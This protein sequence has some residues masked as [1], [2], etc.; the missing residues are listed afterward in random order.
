MENFSNGDDIV[1]CKM[2]KIIPIIAI[3]PDKTVLLFKGGDAIIVRNWQN[4]DWA[5]EILDI[6]K[7]PLI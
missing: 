3:I 4:V 1:S 2:K 6:P 5:A 7:L